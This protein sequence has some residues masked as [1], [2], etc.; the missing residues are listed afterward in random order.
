VRAYPLLALPALSSIQRFLKL[1]TAGGIVL[2]AAAVIAL[3][4]ANSPLETFYTRLL[5]LPVAVE[6]GALAIA[7][8][9]LLWINDG[10]MAIFFRLVGLE[11]KRAVVEGELSSLPNAALPVIAA[12]G[13]MTDPALVYLACNLGDAD[14]LRGLGHSDRD[15]HCLCARRTGA[16]GSASAAITEDLSAGSGDY[17]RSRAI[18][19]SRCSTLPSCR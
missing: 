6:I 3:A 7:K 11:V 5:D 18:I 15:G 4:L 17:R 1:E 8:P 19:L 9:L 13:G 2:G 10:L 12:L 14:A 16:A